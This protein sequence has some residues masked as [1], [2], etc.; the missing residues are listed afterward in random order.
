MR[1]TAARNAH[2]TKTPRP[3]IIIALTSGNSAHSCFAFSITDFDSCA[4]YRSMPSTMSAENKYPAISN[5]ITKMPLEE[6]EGGWGR[7]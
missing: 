5:L 3:C 2:H 4:P 7:E 1:S 6:D